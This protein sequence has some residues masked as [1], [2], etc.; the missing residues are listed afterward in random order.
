MYIY[1]HDIW[2]SDQGVPW[3]ASTK[4]SVVERGLWRDHARRHSILLRSVAGNNIADASGSPVSDSHARLSETSC[5]SM[6]AWSYNSDRFFPFTT[7]ARRLPWDPRFRIRVPGA[8]LEILTPRDTRY[9]YRVHSWSI[10]VY[11]Q[12]SR[13]AGRQISFMHGC[14]CIC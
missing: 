1:T 3:E 7:S 5:R 10:H 8:G 2:R 4:V 14:I 9:T 12:T 6:K 13:Q 11:I